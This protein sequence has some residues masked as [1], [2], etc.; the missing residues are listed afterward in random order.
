MVL[1]IVDTKCDTKV[2]C[3]EV[4]SVYE[5]KPIQSF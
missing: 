5:Q 4:A 3:R 1:K 2:I